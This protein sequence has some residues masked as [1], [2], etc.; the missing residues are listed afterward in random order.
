MR[1]GMRSQK[2]RR[3]QV[4]PQPQ[5]QAAHVS[6]RPEIEDEGMPQATH[7]PPRMLQ[8]A[9]ETRRARIHTRVGLDL[10]PAPQPDLPPAPQPDLQPETHL[11]RTESRVM[12]NGL[13]LST[14]ETA[15]CEELKYLLG[16]SEFRAAN[17]GALRAAQAAARSIA[18]GGDD[19]SIAKA[20]EEAEK[21]MERISEKDVINRFE[22]IRN[23]TTQIMTSNFTFFLDK[24]GK[25]L[26]DK[27]VSNMSYGLVANGL[28]MW[29]RNGHKE[30][31]SLGPVTRTHQNRDILKECGVS[32]IGELLL[33]F[34][35]IY[36]TIEGP[37]SILR[38]MIDTLDFNICHIISESQDILQTKSL[39][40]NGIGGLSVGG[41]FGGSV[42]GIGGSASVPTLPLGYYLVDQ[43]DQGELG[44]KS[45]EDVEDDKLG[46]IAKYLKTYTDS[47]AKSAID[48]PT[49][50]NNT[51]EELIAMTA[52]LSRYIH[53][54]DILDHTLGFRKFKDDYPKQA[55]EVYKK[56]YSDSGGKLY[57]ILDNICENSALTIRENIERNRKTRMRRYAEQPEIMKTY[58]KPHQG[59]D[60]GPNLGPSEAFTSMY[61]YVL[62]VDR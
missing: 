21:S 8:K 39:L 46:R 37:L 35:V 59:V 2:S 16:I 17:T 60:L 23:V 12:V 22:Q 27:T 40:Q 19:A 9:K 33:A 51:K 48:A 4:A 62:N 50:L 58:R 53:N 52:L 44:S 31:T 10:P 20:K 61:P 24:V 34:N 38:D 36:E 45:G 32:E 7:P 13:C 30:T 1:G 14:D 49:Y 26:D 54:L 28:D 11:H 18:S 41:T 15:R 3:P 29:I 43:F 57:D 56:N 25:I 42:M 55:F 5:I 6:R 47:L